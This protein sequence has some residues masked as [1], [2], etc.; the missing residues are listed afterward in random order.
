MCERSKTEGKIIVQLKVGNHSG[1]APITNGALSTIRIVTC[2]APSGV[3]EM[4]PPVI[5]MPSGH[6]VVDNFAGGGMVAPLDR[7]TGTIIGPAIQKD[8][9]TCVKWLAAHPDSGT[10]LL[11]F[12]VPKWAEVV[13]LAL[14]AHKAFPTLH[15]VGWDIAV[16]QDG[17]MLLEGNPRWDPD[18]VV[19]PHRIALSDTQFVPYFKYHIAQPA[20]YSWVGSAAICGVARDGW[21]T[22]EA[23]VLIQDPESGKRLTLILEV[24]PWLPFDYP[25]T[26]QI[27]VD[28]HVKETFEFAQSGTH[29]INL[30][31]TE[32]G[33]I[34]LRIGKWFVPANLGIGSP[35]RR[36]LAYR[37]KEAAL[38]EIPSIVVN[39]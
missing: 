19:L 28:G 29:T 21:L 38:E 2:R 18:V 14:R 9:A 12:A 37:L 36:P 1:L 32:A 10:P 17:P 15:F 13:E 34:A 7:D 24:P 26:L 3:I 30:P 39:N 27:I 6:G 8:P 11:G 20:V 23:R 16:L 4:L 5:R 22:P 35:D 25:A 33:T 31:L